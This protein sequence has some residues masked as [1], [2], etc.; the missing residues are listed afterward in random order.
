MQTNTLPLVPSFRGLGHSGELQLPLRKR[1]VKP[2]GPDDSTVRE[3][4]S[5]RAG[6]TF[7]SARIRNL[8]G[9][10]D[11]VEA[12]GTLKFERG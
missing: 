4:T 11:T 10:I 8:A 3:A 12:V 7:R 5:P 9:E 2:I 1:I 6:A